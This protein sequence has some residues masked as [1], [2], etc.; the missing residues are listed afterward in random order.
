MVAWDACLPSPDLLTLLHL[1]QIMCPPNIYGN[2]V[3]VYGDGTDGHDS[4]TIEDTVLEVRHHLASIAFVAV[5]KEKNCSWAVLLP[6]QGV[7]QP[8][9]DPLKR[10]IYAYARVTG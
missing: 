8:A 4:F 7:H 9:D 10:I 5:V 1:P 3:K 2:V 6:L